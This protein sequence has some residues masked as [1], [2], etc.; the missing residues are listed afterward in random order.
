MYAKLERN[1]NFDL[2]GE[3]EKKKKAV[4]KIKLKYAKKNVYRKTEKPI[5]LDRQPGLG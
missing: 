1:A 4:M 2:S 3:F 5:T